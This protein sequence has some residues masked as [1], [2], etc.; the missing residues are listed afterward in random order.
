MSI[1]A[2]GACSDQSTPTVSLLS[3]QWSCNWSSLSPFTDESPRAQRWHSL[4]LNSRMSL[5]SL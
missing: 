4:N 2:N 1:A 3:S 5:W